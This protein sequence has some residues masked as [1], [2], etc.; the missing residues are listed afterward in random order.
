MVCSSLQINLMGFNF[1]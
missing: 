1:V